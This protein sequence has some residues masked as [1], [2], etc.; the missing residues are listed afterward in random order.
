MSR[1][2]YKIGQWVT[3]LDGFSNTREGKENYGGSG[4]VP[5]KTFLI[6]SIASEI[7][8]PENSNG[9]YIKAIRPALPHEIPGN[10]QKYEVGGYFE[11]NQ[12]GSMYKIL[13]LNPFKCK[14][15]WSD[16]EYGDHND[17]P[18]SWFIE[19]HKD[20]YTYIPPSNKQQE[21]DLQV[22]DTFRNSVGNKK[23][24]VEIRGWEHIIEDCITYKRSYNMMRTDIEHNIR[25]G[26][27]TDYTP[28]SQQKTMKQWKKED[29]LNTKIIVDTPEKSRRFQELMFSLGIQW[30]RNGR[31]VSYLTSPYLSVGKDA[32]LQHFL[33]SKSIDFTNLSK[34]EI[35]YNE[36]FNENNNQL[37]NNQ[38]G[39]TENNDLFRKNFSGNGS[40]EAATAIS[41][42]RTSKIA[43]SSGY[44]G[45]KI[46]GRRVDTKIGRS[47]INF[48]AISI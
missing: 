5:N 4:Y 18:I 13:S 39:K 24:I 21:I 38:N 28:V 2:K 46:Q 45:N 35:F 8:W 43:T 44:T 25:S 7:V 9:I 19:K 36:I 41:F 26:K 30:C 40:K 14:S 15:E 42:R 12:D 20:K 31:N 22:G 34:S 6:K 1:Q 10:Q 37:N 23:E 48:S 47:E 17:Y 33:G 3:T 27:Y 11:Y 32:C 29:F 16:L